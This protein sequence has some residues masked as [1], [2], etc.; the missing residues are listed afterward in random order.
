MRHVSG[1]ELLGGIR[2]YALAQFG[3]MTQMVFEEWGI[4]RCEDFGEIV[5]NMVE[6]GLLGKTEKDSREDFANGYDFDDAFRK[7]FRPA[8]RIAASQDIPKSAEA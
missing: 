8:S 3:P 1:Q 4:K 6:I 7:P 2:D 5:F